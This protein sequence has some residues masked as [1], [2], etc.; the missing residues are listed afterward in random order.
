MEVLIR[1]EKASALL[2]P[3]FERFASVCAGA[4]GRCPSCEEFGFIDHADARHTVQAQ[5]CRACGYRWEYEFR[6]DGKILEVRG[7]RP[8]G[9]V[10]ELDPALEE[11]T[12][13]DLRESNGEPGDRHYIVLTYRHRGPARNRD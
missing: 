12:V 11:E 3:L 8:L 4:P 1:F 13:L 5:H 6:P 9:P 2:H 10:I 7:S